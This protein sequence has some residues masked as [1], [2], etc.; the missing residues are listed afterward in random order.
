MIFFKNAQDRGENIKFQ[1]IDHELHLRVDFQKILN[2]LLKA[3]GGDDERQRRNRKIAHGTAAGVLHDGNV[4][5]TEF[6]NVFFHGIAVMFI[7]FHGD[8]L[9]VAGDHGGFHSDA[10]IADDTDGVLIVQMKFIDDYGTD[11]TG[12]VTDRALRKIIVLHADP[13]G[14]SGV[15]IENQHNGRAGDL[16]IDHFGKLAYIYAAFRIQP[17]FEPDVAVAETVIPKIK[18]KVRISGIGKNENSFVCL[19][20]RDQVLLFFTDIN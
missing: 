10:L 14:T 3:F 15:W 12:H 17:G 5:Q 8:D 18:E 11:L 13:V 9:S 4:G 7:V 2:L 1:R 6:V 19:N 20:S 16:R